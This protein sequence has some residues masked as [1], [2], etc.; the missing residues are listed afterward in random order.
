MKSTLTDVRCSVFD[1]IV[2]AVDG[3]VASLAAARQAGVLRSGSGTIE[4]VGVVE[5][6]AGGYSIYGGPAIVSEA[7]TSLAAELS[8]ARLVCPGASS[9]LLQGRT[10][11]RLLE[12]L[13]EGNATL[14][15]VGASSRNRGIGTI[16]GSVTTAMLHRARSSVL[17]ARSSSAPDS[18]P[19]SVVVG[20]DG[21]KG[22]DA[23]LSAGRDLA[24]R[25]AAILRVIAA[26]D[27]VGVGSDALA[28]LSLERDERGALEAL[29]DASKGAD[30]VVVGSRG[31]HGLHALGSISER[32]GHQAACSVLVVR[33]SPL[34]DSTLHTA[35]PGSRASRRASWPGLVSESSTTKKPATETIDFLTRERQTILEAAETMLIQAHLQHYDAA[36]E[37]EIKGRLRELFDRLLESLEKQ[38]LTPVVTHAHRIAEER[39]TSGYDLSEVQIALNALEAAIWARVFSAVEPDQ[40]ARTLGLVST[41]LGAGKDALA[42]KYVSLATDTHT[43]SLNLRALF[44]GTDG[45]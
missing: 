4:L 31:L 26:G 34:H 35:P 38:D 1:R 18:F 2:C 21:S 13:I 10:S 40:F 12:R 16:R 14:V 20:Y 7:E 8:E 22:A 37:L 9:E 28:G 15:A 45:T 29:L 27:A 6:S 39:F 23:A 5:P 33:E 42:R 3:S 11:G 41:I 24:A 43:P 36:G 30:L 32:V 17:V 25:F 44:A 19:R